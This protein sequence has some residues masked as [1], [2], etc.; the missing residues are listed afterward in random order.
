MFERVSIEQYLLFLTYCLEYRALALE[1]M[2][3]ELEREYLRNHPNIDEREDG[4]G[5]VIKYFAIRDMKGT[6]L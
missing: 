4:Y 3:E 6:Y 1:Q 5:V 2:S